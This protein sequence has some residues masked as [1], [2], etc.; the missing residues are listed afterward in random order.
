MVDV[1][2]GKRRAGEMTGIMRARDRAAA[3]QLA[4]PHGLC[5]REVTYDGRRPAHGGPPRRRRHA[6]QR[7]SASSDLVAVAAQLGDDGLAV[8]AGCGPRR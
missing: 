4:P 7:F 1:G 5:L 8:L 6:C 3:G 2:L